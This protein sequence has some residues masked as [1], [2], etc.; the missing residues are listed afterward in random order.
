MRFNGTKNYISTDD[1][2]IAV[3]A[4]ISLSTIR[5]RVVRIDGALHRCLAPNSTL[6]SQPARTVTSSRA[7]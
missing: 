4:S 6:G 1:L 7:F 2:N 3:N 5:A